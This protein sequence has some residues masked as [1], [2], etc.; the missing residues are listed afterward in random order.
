MI[1][2]MFN[3][4]FLPVAIAITTTIV[5]TVI[6]QFLFEI[7]TAPQTQY[8]ALILGLDDYSLLNVVQQ[9]TSGLITKEQPH[10]FRIFDIYDSN[11]RLTDNLWF[12]QKILL[13]REI[14]IDWNQYRYIP[15]NITN[16]GLASTKGLV[17]HD[18]FQ[19]RP[20]PMTWPEFSVSASLGETPVESQLSARDVKIAATY[21]VYLYVSSDLLCASYGAD[22]SLTRIM[23]SSKKNMGFYHA[24]KF[25][26]PDNSYVDYQLPTRLAIE[27]KSPPINSVIQS[28][29]DHVKSSTQQKSKLVECFIIGR[30]YDLNTIC[31]RSFD[32]SGLPVS[33]KVY[34]YRKRPWDEEIAQSYWGKELTN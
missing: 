23:H 15:I 12:K 22:G 2:K 14:L 6:Y 28:G 19:P 18:R 13:S 24:K 4:Q 29:L 20:P 33:E 7:F 1:K 30:S 10:R 32:A 34:E 26:N 16:S 25:P 17:V 9:N 3:R 5:I 8:G 27:L 31:V 11:N 21:L